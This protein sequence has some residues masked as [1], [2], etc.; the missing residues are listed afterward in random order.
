MKP[1]LPNAQVYKRATEQPKN[2]TPE[3]ARFE[4]A[5]KR[6]MSLRKGDPLIVNRYPDG[7]YEFEIGARFKI[8]ELEK[9]EGFKCYRTQGTSS[10]LSL[11]NMV[12]GYYNLDAF[13]RQGSFISEDY[14]SLPDSRILSLPRNYAAAIR[15]IEEKYIGKT[16]RVV[17]KS[18][19]GSSIIN[20]GCYYLFA[21][22]D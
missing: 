15:V 20:N 17:A 11:Y 12:G 5:F 14:Y 13:N 10:I 9:S 18:P 8:L 22:D 4:E 16:F 21:I 3:Q 1:F 7:S 2:Q 6:V 19:K